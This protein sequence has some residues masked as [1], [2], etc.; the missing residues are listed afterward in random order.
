LFKLYEKAGPAT[1]GGPFVKKQ[2]EMEGSVMR[3]PVLDLEFKWIGWPAA[4][5]RM[6]NLASQRK[7][8]EPESSILPLCKWLKADPS[9]HV[10]IVDDIGMENI[11]NYTSEQLELLIDTAYN[12]EGIFFWTSEWVTASKDEGEKTLR[13]LYSYRLVSR[14][15]GLAPMV[16]LPADMSDL[17][18]R[19]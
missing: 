2:G 19:L 8:E 6:K 16:Q 14:L 17:R 12:H 9:R 5:T 7:W 11:G 15:I 10:L 18:V 3:V 4:A 13:K 1:Y